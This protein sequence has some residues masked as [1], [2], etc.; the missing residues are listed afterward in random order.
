MSA[1]QYLKITICG[2]TTL[3]NT[4][5]STPI[6]QRDL[7]RGQQK[8]RV[9]LHLTTGAVLPWCGHSQP[10][11]ELP[12]HPFVFPGYWQ[13]RKGHSQTLKPWRTV[14][15]HLIPRTNHGCDDRFHCEAENEFCWSIG[16]TCSAL[17]VGRFYQ[18]PVHCCI[19]RGLIR[20]SKASGSFHWRGEI[21]TR[22]CWHAVICNHGTG[23]LH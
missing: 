8:C 19:R 17:R 11:R 12:Q 4:R 9:W 15:W 7:K 10:K 20:Q 21:H 14:C 16:W 3:R 6:F 1:L 18:R 22:T 2:G 13:K 23:A 5:L